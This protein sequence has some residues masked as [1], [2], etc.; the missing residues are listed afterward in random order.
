MNSLNSV[1]LEGVLTA[2]PA[3][4]YEPTSAALCTFFIASHRD[5]KDS[6]E[7]IIREPLI[8]EVRAHSHLAEVCQ[9]YLK[10]GRGVRVVGRLTM[11]PASH[12]LFLTAEHV[13]FK[14]ERSKAKPP[15]VPATPAKKPARIQKAPKD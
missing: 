7:A 12:C 11:E 2:D 13:E 3:L 4:S 5:L 1:L 10:A 6:G 8:T 9:E 14:P 15:V